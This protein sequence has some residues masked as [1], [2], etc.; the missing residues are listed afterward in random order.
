MDLYLKKVLFLVSFSCLNVN[1]S[2]VDN[3]DFL[4]IMFSDKEE[5]NIL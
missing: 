3:S 5:E 1:E 4:V 2:F